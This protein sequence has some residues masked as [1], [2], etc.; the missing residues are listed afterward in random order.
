[1][2]LVKI[3]ILKGKSVGHKK[4]LFEGVHKA[5]VDTLKIPDHDR[6]QRI[7]ELEPDHFEVPPGK[8]GNIILIEIV[9][10]HGRS[11]NA[12]KALYK[13]IVA[14]LAENPGIS[15][16]DITIVLNEQPLENWGLRGGKIA[17]EI[18]FG[19]KIDV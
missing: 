18:D 12:K 10:F 4:A 13:A 14:N 16:T 7:Y 17:T 5:L 3:E 1:M 15:D 6:T 11:A 9:M 2:P 8:T 19:F